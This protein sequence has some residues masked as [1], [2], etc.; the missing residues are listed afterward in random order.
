MRTNAHLGATARKVS[1]KSQAREELANK[2]KGGLL[3]KRMVLPPYGYVE[4]LGSYAHDIDVV[5]AARVSTD[6]Q[7][8][9]M[10]DA[11]KGL[12]NFLMRNKHTSPF[13][14]TFFKWMIKCPIF[15][16]REF[17]RHRTFSFSERSGRYTELDC[18]FY[19]PDADHWRAQVGAPGHYEYKK[20][21][22]ANTWDRI[23]ATE[24]ACR[25]AYKI[26]QRLGEY[27]VAREQARM[28]LPLNIY[29]EFIAST[30]AHNLMHFLTLRNAP[31][32]Q[33]EIRVYAQ[34]MENDFAAIMPVTHEAFRKYNELEQAII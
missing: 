34:A 21:E 1:A 27:G 18:E 9:A 7:T 16:A 11:E 6:R 5:E 25:E 20:L 22:D 2:R 29:T 10:G 26:Y 32:A 31:D 12:I 14:H 30:D 4:L 23:G 33:Y 3:S 19:I 24:D 8:T 15:V 28:V 13:E 17:Q